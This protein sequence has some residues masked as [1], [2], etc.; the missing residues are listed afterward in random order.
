MKQ[1][2]VEDCNCPSPEEQIPTKK[3][4]WERSQLPA[5][6]KRAEFRARLHHAE[7]GVARDDANNLGRATGDTAHDG[8]LI[9]VPAHKPPDQTPDRLI[10][11]R[12]HTF[13]P[14]YTAA[15]H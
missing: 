9:D 7:D 12:P 11:R 5:C 2:A 4:C 6:G 10:R 13:F 8:H 1:S 15:L 3:R 14:W